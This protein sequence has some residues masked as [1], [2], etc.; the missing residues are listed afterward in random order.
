MGAELEHL[1]ATRGD[2]VRAVRTDAAGRGGKRPTQVSD[3]SKRGGRARYDG[4][5]RIAF[6][7]FESSVD[8]GRQQLSRQP[9]DCRKLVWRPGLHDQPERVHEPFSADVLFRQS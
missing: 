3:R 8:P 7:C 4:Q 9:G 5:A 2:G 1:A 6:D